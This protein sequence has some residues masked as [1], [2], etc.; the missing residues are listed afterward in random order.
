MQNF[1]VC[2]NIAL[3]KTVLSIFTKQSPLGGLK[4]HRN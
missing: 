4:E 2:L 3:T 1:A